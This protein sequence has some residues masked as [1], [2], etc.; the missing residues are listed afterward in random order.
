MII[1]IAI[2]VIGLCFTIFVMMY[3]DRKY[4]HEFEDDEGM[5]VPLSFIWP[6]NLV[7]IVGFLFFSKLMAYY[8]EIINEM[9]GDK[10]E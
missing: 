8:K 5:L 10:E 6:L 1:G 7:F 3:F 4:W 2:Y 9:V